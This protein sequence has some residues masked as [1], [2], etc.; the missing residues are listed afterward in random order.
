MRKLILFAC[1]ALFVSQAYAAVTVGQFIDRIATTRDVSGLKL[2]RNQELTEGLLVK[3]S[4]AIGIRVT[5][6]T[7]DKVVTA[8]QVDT[9]FDAFKSQ[10]YVTPPGVPPGP[11]P[12]GPP[13]QG[14]THK[15]PSNQ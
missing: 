5:T 8:K 10:L 2:D 7:P 13:G 1:L 14:R 15:S 3:I 11:P 4:D 12:G 9:F 6:S